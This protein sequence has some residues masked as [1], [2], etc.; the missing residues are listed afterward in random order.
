MNIRTSHEYKMHTNQDGVVANAVLVGIFIISDAMV[1]K[2][3]YNSFCLSVS[4]HP[5]PYT[6]SHLLAT[7]ECYIW[8][9]TTRRHLGSLH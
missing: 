5:N 1:H 2:I 6:I 8:R 9:L 7:P 4:A 3:L